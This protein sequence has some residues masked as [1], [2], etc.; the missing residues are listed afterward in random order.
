[1]VTAATAAAAV[2]LL[3][4]GIIVMT[5]AAVSAALTLLFFGIIVM[6]AATAAATAVSCLF[7]L[8]AA[9]RKFCAS[10]SIGLYVVGIV[11]EFADSSAQIR[12]RSLGS[13]IR[14]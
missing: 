1:M 12:N 3:F 13:V 2:T 7:G 4:F 11:T 8:G 14:I 6:T 5:A 9:S 10:S